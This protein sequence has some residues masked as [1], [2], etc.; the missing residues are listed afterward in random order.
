MLVFLTDTI[1]PAIDG[2]VSF[3]LCRNGVSKVYDSVR[4]YCLLIGRYDKRQMLKSVG[5]VSREHRT[6]KIDR[7]DNA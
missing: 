7:F 2:R 6:H 1:D 5:E 4:Q 3:Q